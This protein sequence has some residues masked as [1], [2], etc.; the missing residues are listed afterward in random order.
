[1]FN[2]TIRSTYDDK[3]EIT[4]DQIKDLMTYNK[5]VIDTTTKL[6]ITNKLLTTMDDYSAVVETLFIIVQKV[7]TLLGPS[8]NFEKNLEE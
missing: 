3:Y 7:K 4:N 1:M 6:Q 8:T 2:I 5:K